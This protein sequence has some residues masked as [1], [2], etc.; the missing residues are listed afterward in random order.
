MLQIF[1]NKHLVKW[2]KMTPRQAIHW[3]ERGL[4]TNEIDS[5][6]RGSQRGYTIFG[7]FEA[8]VVKALFDMG[9]SLH[10]VKSIMAQFVRDEKYWNIVDQVDK[11]DFDIRKGIFGVLL[12]YFM[13]DDSAKMII[14]LR[15]VQEILLDQI[16]NGLQPEEILKIKSFIFLDVGSIW[17]LVHRETAKVPLE[18][19]VDM[20]ISNKIGAYLKKLRK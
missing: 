5:K 16:Q 20:E 7:V 9:L 14:S 19:V 10:M 12:Y 6:G 3:T 8:G 4:I 2:F 11:P 13:K 18:E 1:S 15:T 17:F